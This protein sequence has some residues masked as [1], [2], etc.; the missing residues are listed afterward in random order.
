M[1]VLIRDETFTRGKHRLQVFYIEYPLGV[2]VQYKIVY[3]IIHI[4]LYH[5]PSH[6][7]THKAGRGWL[8]APHYFPTTVFVFLPYT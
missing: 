6:P 8:A 7:S 4:Y 5:N 3:Y 2:H 1:V